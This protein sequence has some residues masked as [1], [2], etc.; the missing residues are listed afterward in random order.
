M[1]P[2][3]RS[4]VARIK[5]DPSSLTEVDLDIVQHVLLR[6]DDLTSPQLKSTDPSWE[7]LMSALRADRGIMGRKTPQLIAVEQVLVVYQIG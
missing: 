2:L 5:D 3:A 1:V 4:I 7:L 6:Y